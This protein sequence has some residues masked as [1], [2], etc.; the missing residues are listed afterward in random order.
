MEN[1]IGKRIKIIGEHAHSGESGTIDR[2]EQTAFGSIGV[3][4][5]LQDCEHGTN[6]CFVFRRENMKFIK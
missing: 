4:V 3:V 1:I 6:E 2:V 5:K